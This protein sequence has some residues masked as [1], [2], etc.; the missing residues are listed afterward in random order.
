MKL[1]Y[2]M[3]MKMAMMDKKKGGKGTRR[4]SVDSM[5]SN[6]SGRSATPKSAVK[7]MKAMKLSYYMAM[8][9]AMMD[10]KKGGKETRRPSV[11][12][13]KSN[14]SGRSAT[15]KSAVKGMKA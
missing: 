12:S 8:K 1:S 4:S 14:M 15:P 13:M 11:D 10:K 2:Y 5:R 9:M 6:V 3:A 7:G